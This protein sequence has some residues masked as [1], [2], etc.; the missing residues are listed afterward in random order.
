MPCSLTRPCGGDVHVVVQGPDFV[1][2][3]CRAAHSFR[4]GRPAITPPA[5]LVGPARCRGCDL[6]VPTG[7]SAWCSDACYARRRNEAPAGRRGR[8]RKVRA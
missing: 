5:P 8:P 7:R 6:V 1:V 3:E 2:V 4:L